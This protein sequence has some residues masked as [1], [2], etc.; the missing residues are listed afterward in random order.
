MIIRFEEENVVIQVDAKKQVSR[1]V[2]QGQDFLLLQR[3][4][5]EEEEVGGGEDQKKSRRSGERGGIETRAGASRN[6]ERRWPPVQACRTPPLHWDPSSPI[7][8]L[9]NIL[10]FFLVFGRWAQ[11][12]YYCFFFLLL[13]SFYSP[14]FWKAFGLRFWNHPTPKTLTVTLGGRFSPTENVPKRGGGKKR[15]NKMHKK[16]MMKRRRRMSPQF[17]CNQEGWGGCF[18]RLRPP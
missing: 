11:I 7:F 17:G 3:Q 16:M 1:K 14:S 12:L 9:F 15:M 2:L 6:E 10:L 8:L 4:E 18:A 5:E 13:F